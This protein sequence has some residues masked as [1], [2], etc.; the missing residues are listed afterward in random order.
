VLKPKEKT[1]WKLVEEE[2]EIEDEVQIANLFNKFFVEI[3][4]SEGRN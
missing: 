3:F 1:Q 4:F 2:Q